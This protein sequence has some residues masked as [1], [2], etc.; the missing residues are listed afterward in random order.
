MGTEREPLLRSDRGDNIAES[1]RGEIIRTNR[2]C[3]SN[4]T[5]LTVSQYVK[6]FC[7]SCW[8]LENV[9]NKF[10]ITKWLPHYKLYDLQSDVIAG[11]SVALTVIPQGLAY[12]NIA[13]LP[14]QYG[15]YSAFMGC[16]IYCIFGTSKDITLG[17]T[18]IM[19]LMTST[20]ATSPEKWD[21]TYAIILTLACGVV[22]FLMGI[23]QLGIVVNF[24]SYP[25]INAFTSAAAITIAFGQVKG[26]LGL[27][28]IPRDFL[29]EVYE[30]F[31][32]IPDTKVWDLVM[33]V[34][35]LILLYLIKKL[36]NIKWKEVPDQELS[37]KQVIVRKAVWLTGISANAIIVIVAAFIAAIYIHY[38]VK[39]L[40]ITG[41]IRAGLPPFQLPNFSLSYQS[42]NQTVHK[43]FGDVLSHIGSGLLIVPLL[44][45]VE[46]IAIGK[47]F[48]RQNNYKILPN[49]ELIA[50]GVSNIASC[51]VS[52][53]PVTGS[54]SRTAV[55]SQ[56]G[57]R[58]PASGI[59]T[60][61]VVI[62]ALQVLT[63][64]C[65]YIPKSALSAV[66][67]S[68]VLQMVDYK[69]VMKLWKVGKIDLV[70][71]FFTFVTSFLLGIEYG[72]LIG[73]GI[74]LLILLYP[75]AR[76]SMTVQ[77]LDTLVIRFDQGLRFPSIEY[78]QTQ[79]L[80]EM[81]SGEKPKSVILDCTHVSAVDYTTIQG[82]IELI[83][84]FL[85]ND[86]RF[87][88][89]SAPPHIMKMLEKAE[90]PNL[91]CGLTVEE[92]M[93]MIDE[94]RYDEDELLTIQALN[95]AVPVSGSTQ[96]T[97]RSS[98]DPI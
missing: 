72:I 5:S 7:A 85:R 54:F 73:I 33:G 19:S 21:P 37:L 3:S 92:T 13:G 38:D 77:Y 48:A 89:A 63:P 9:K 39:E 76:P 14:S 86:V 47:A 36:R 68:A 15:L 75:L 50:I 11:L 44:G 55:N 49:Q 60:G 58:T 83:A 74:S 51:F 98:V 1:E 35:C 69:I 6:Q 8:T 23:F 61:A 20:F 2:T 10:P 94:A 78:V 30:T 34:C 26:I 31:K 93:K 82:I 64:L 16:F 41:D 96:D 28:N 25:V 57:V 27:K 65:Y 97:N 88:V 52:S 43:H 40:T 81:N 95:G 87:A 29:S 80:Q 91:I 17:P 84:D 46:A 59:F 56:S 42:A 53:Y 67:I 90:V 70:P 22:Q 66:I 32:H 45:L 12:A 71:M 62:L 18:A 79:I 24:I 4:R